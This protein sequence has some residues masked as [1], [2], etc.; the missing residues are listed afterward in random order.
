MQTWLIFILIGIL[1][2]GVTISISMSMVLSR[3]IKMMRERLQPKGPRPGTPFPFE[4]LVPFKEGGSDPREASKF[5]I[6]SA[7][8]SACSELLGSLVDLSLSGRKS[9]GSQSP[10]AAVWIGADN[11]T[12]YDRLETLSS[13]IPVFV[14]SEYPPLT[15]SIHLE[16]SPCLLSMSSNGQITGHSS[17]PA[18]L[19]E[20]IVAGP[21][22]NA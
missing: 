5:L 22:D 20:S 12:P 16:Y 17:A 19:I 10:L 14:D 15:E 13:L 7:N 21:V 2:I 4:R 9:S 3:E 8:C 1:A 18:G 11:T 6:M